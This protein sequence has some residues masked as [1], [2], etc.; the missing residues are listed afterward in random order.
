[1]AGLFALAIA[2]GSLAGRASLVS[3]GVWLP[4]AVVGGLAAGVV[5]LALGP[6]ACLVA[7]VGLSVTGISPHLA[8]VQGVDISVADPL[9]VVIVCWLAFERTTGRRPPRERI[10]FGQSA[11][12]LFF[13]YIAASVIAVAVVEPDRF[14]AALTSFLRLTQTASLAWLAAGVVRSR[15]DVVLLVRWLLVATAVGVLVALGYAISGG[16]LIGTRYGGLLDPNALGLIAAVTA[17]AAVMGVGSRQLGVRVALGCVGALGLVLGKSVGAFL[18]LAAA[19]LLLL[20]TASVSRETPFGQRLGQGL[21][22]VLLVGVLAFGAIQFFRP[23]ALPTSSQFRNSS[24]QHRI[25]AGT[26]GLDLFSDSPI[27]GLGWR[28]SDSPSV[29]A[30]SHLADR[31]RQRFGT[32]L[33][34]SFFPDVLLVTVH[35]TYVELLAELGVLGVLALLFALWAVARRVRALL[36]RLTQHSELEH[37]ARFLALAALA[38]LVWLNDNPLYGGQPETI[39][40]AVTIGALA[41]IA[42]VCPPEQLPAEHSRLALHP[43][44]REHPSSDGAE[45]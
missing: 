20:S 14:A 34:P 5:L 26:G 21:L 7:A 41:A 38:V 4:L 31:L 25:V 29:I 12:L 2:L 36:R 43:G 22:V 3:G 30:K 17:L 33:N 39:L 11:V 44:D 23:T 42:H 40:L 9:Y 28:R 37:H 6:F 15:R 19:L 27:V 10:E 1:M 8:T 35:N 13:F 16:D 32:D 24:T 18:S 45:I